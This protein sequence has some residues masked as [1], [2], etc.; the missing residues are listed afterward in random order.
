MDKKIFNYRLSR[1]R[2]VV[3]NA[4]GILVSR[5]GLFQKQISLSPEKA[6]I[7]VMACCYLHNYLRNRQP[8][9]Y[10]TRRDIDDEDLQAGTL[11]R[12]A[13]REAVA[14]EGTP[15]QATVSRNAPSTAKTVRDT[16]CHFFNNVGQVSWQLKAVS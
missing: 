16:Y 15:L 12:G 14:N 10:I 3:E 2:R 9:T 8:R 1:A 4:Y 11:T 7:L 6:Q 5:F 13:W